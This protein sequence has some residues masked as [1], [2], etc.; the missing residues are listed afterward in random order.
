MK[1]L[2]YT[3]GLIGLV[4]LIFLLIGVFSKTTEFKQE[5]SINQPTELVFGAIM[6]PRRMQDWVEGLEKIEPV[7]GFMNGIGTQY[8][9]SFNYKNSK[10]TILQKVLGFQ[11]KKQL[12]LMFYPPHMNIRM[13]LRFDE[14]NNST[15]M[16]LNTTITGDNLFWRSVLFLKKPA[17]KK[18]INR[19][20]EN[21][22]Q[23]LNT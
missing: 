18:I 8:M 5:F 14:Y 13:D 15:N 16:I 21:L 9:I 22:E 20:I 11:W 6:D 23:M 19:N 12:D 3:S 17:I 7:N 2:K 1:L 4:I 10:F